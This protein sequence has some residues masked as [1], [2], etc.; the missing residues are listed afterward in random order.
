MDASKYIVMCLL[1]TLSFFFVTASAA[2]AEPGI[3]VYPAAAGCNTGIAAVV[4]PGGSYAM[5]SLP[6][7]GTP[8][9][10]F[11]AENGISAAVVEYTLPQGHKERPLADVRRAFSELRRRAGELCIDTAK[12]GIVG[13]SAGGH[14]AATFST[15]KGGQS[16][17]AFTVLLY[18][19]ISSRAGLAHQRSFRNLL[20]DNA[21]LQERA[22]YSCEL[23]VDSSTPP[24][25]LILSDDDPTV[26]PVNSIE[27]Y[28][29]LKRFGIP[30]SMHIY[31]RGKHGFGFTDRFPY[32]DSVKDLLLDWLYNLYDNDKKNE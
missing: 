6:N 17:P 16:K 5:V 23:R 13:S 24:A 25:F 29:A 8:V 20:G 12:I 21:S 9:A 18:P 4:C 3:I 19:V 30:A 31:P 10:E 27:Y 11:L 28:L 1:A 32:L 26:D 2:A 14:L 15:E 7:E 22:E